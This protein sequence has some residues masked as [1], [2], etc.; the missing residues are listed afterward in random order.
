MSTSDQDPTTGFSNAGFPNAG[1]SDRLKPAMP[2]DETS[3]SGLL[4]DVNMLT[5]M[6]NEF[7][8]AQP[9]QGFP[10]TAAPYTPDAQD[11]PPA[12]ETRLPQFGMPLPS[13]PASHPPVR[14]PPWRPTC[15]GL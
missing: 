2:V 4:P 3:L 12:F 11:L 1:F 5:R 6:A 13:M 9:G 14:F 15:L 10:A 8:R 7:F